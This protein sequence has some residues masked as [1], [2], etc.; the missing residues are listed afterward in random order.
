MGRGPS[1]PFTGL[2]ESIGF[3]RKMY[4]YTKKAPAPLYSV[5]STAWKYSESSSSGHKVVAALRAFGLV[6]NVPV[7]GDSWSIR[8]TPR[9]VLILL[10]DK[11]SPEWREELKKAA[12][13][14][15]WYARCWKKWGADMPPSMRSNLLVHEGFVES[16]VDAFLRDYRKTIAFVGLVEEE[17]AEVTEE[18]S[19]TERNSPLGDG[20]QSQLPGSAAGLRVLPL[21]GSV[22]PPQATGVI[23]NYGGGPLM[24]VESFRLSDGISVS[25]E[26]PQ[27]ISSDSFEDFKE[28][29]DLIKKRVGRAVRAPENKAPSPS[30]ADGTET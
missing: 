12:L 26:W 18:S 24:S 8:L 6:E 16:T 1:Y 3:A 4:D 30:D 11:D 29:L 27:A 9:A 20:V 25:V 5:I 21:P 14:P 17:G 22:V 15:N 28:W 19:P 2:E 7:D 13:S 10:G 23:R